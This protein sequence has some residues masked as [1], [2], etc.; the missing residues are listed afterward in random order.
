MGMYTQCRGWLN[1]DSISYMKDKISAFENLLRE[2]Q[3]KFVET[4]DGRTFVCYDTW[5]HEGSNGSTFIFFG[6]ELKNYDR[7]FERWVEFLLKYFPNAEGRLDIQYEEDDIFG[8]TTYLEIC[9]G[10]IAEKTCKTWCK[11]YGNMWVNK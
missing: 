6:T 10:R 11:G 3:E 8:K 4:Q 1:I 9:E 7:D 5:I 2:A